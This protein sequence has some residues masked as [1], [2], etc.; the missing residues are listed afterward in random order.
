[1]NRK[2]ICRSAY[3]IKAPIIKRGD[4]I[5]NIVSEAVLIATEIRVPSG[6]Q[7][8]LNNNDIV[9]VT[10]SVV[11]RSLGRYATI[12]DIAKDVQNKYGAK[13][14]LVLYNMIYSRNRFAM[15]LKGIARGCKGGTIA[16]YMPEMDEVGNVC[17]NHP[18]TG[19]DYTKYYKEIIESEG[20]KCIIHDYDFEYEYSSMYKNVLYCGLHDYE[21]EKMKHS[22]LSID[23]H[24]YTLADILSDKCDWGVLGSNKAT[25]DTIKLYPNKKESTDICNKIKKTIFDIT[26][27]DVI[28]CVYGDGC[29][30]SPMINNIDGTSINEFADP[31][32]MPGYTNPEIIESTPNEIKIKAFADDKYKDLNGKNLDEAI[33]NE[34][35]E[36][37]KVLVGNMSSQGTT[38]RLYRDLIASACDLVSGSGDCGTPIV[39]LKNWFNNYSD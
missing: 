38:P 35:K 29:F 27:K 28:V 23:K 2:S 32:T 33:K 1:M 30:H 3:G 22:T 18:F 12:D 39:L 24:F 14:F 11:A 20:T 10:E 7:Y 6:A 17:K 16:L 8:D 26:G 25:E 19:M 15:I 37:K 34:I 36:K 13:P 21:N 9:S 5:A 31:V 4:D